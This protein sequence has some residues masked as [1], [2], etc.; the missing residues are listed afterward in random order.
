M[1]KHGKVKYFF[2]ISILSLTF[3]NGFQTNWQG[4]ISTHNKVIYIN[5]PE[6]PLFKSTKSLY[7]REIRIG[8]EDGDSTQVFAN[9]LSAATDD[10]I[11]IYIL[12]PWYVKKFSNNGKYLITFGQ[13]G[14]GPGELNGPLLLCANSKKELF[15]YEANGRRISI[16]N[17]N[18]TFLHCFNI[19]QSNVFSMVVDSNGNIYIAS[20]HDNS[21]IH[22]YSRNGKYLMSFGDY[23]SSIVAGYEFAME[24]GKLAINKNDEIY[25]SEPNEYKIRIFAKSGELIKVILVKNKSFYPPAIQ[26]VD[27]RLRYDAGVTIVEL[28]VTPK[29]FIFHQYLDRKN[30]NIITDIL[31][32]RGIFILR[33]IEKNDL[34]GGNPR[35]KL[36]GATVNDHLIFR[37]LRPYP[38]LEIYSISLTAFKEPE[39]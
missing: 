2:Y 20:Y 30:F 36:L 18:G 17:Q 21:V 15:I 39:Y 37:R 14:A 22:K 6:Q 7:K 8:R 35:G 13:R 10:S 28:V 5:N 16:F 11:N 9:I 19:R 24:G 29:N 4:K 32:P 34:K 31:S 1:K 26:S 25:L 27:G 33:T 23:P 12:E 3:Y 38:F